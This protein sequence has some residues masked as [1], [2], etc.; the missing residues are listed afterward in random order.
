[1]K[2]VP[3]RL[4]PAGVS[5]GGPVFNGPLAPESSQEYDNEHE[6]HAHDIPRSAYLTRKAYPSRRRIRGR[7]LHKALLALPGS[8]YKGGTLDGCPLGCVACERYHKEESMRTLASLLAACF[9]LGTLG[10]GCNDPNSPEYWI[11]KLKDI[12]ERKEARRQLVRLDKPEAVPA[13]IDLYKEDK[14]PET[15]KALVHFHDKRSIPLLISVIQE[16]T[17]ESVDAASVAAAELGNLGDPQA[18]DP[19]IK[20]LEKKLPIRS[21]ANI[22]KQEAMRSLAKFG[23]EPRVVDALMKMLTTS[24]DEQDFFLNKFAAVQLGVI[25]DPKAVPALIKGLFMTGRGADIFQECR[26]ALVRIGEPAVDPLIELFQEKNAEVNEM[27]KALEFDKHTPG[28]IPAKAAYVLGDLRPK[29]ALPLL[30]ARLKEKVKDPR[31]NMRIS[32]LVTLGQYGD[33]SVIPDILA[34]LKDNTASDLERAKAAEALNFIGDRKVLPE[35]FACVSNQKT[36]PNVRVA[37]GFAYAS[38]GTLAEYAKFEPLANKDAYEEFKMAL[39]RLKLAK[40]CKEDAACY[41]KVFAGSTTQS[42]VLHQMLKAAYELG[43]LERNAALR[44]ILE[45][46]GKTD[47]LEVE[48]ALLFALMRQAGKDCKECKEKLQA[49][50]ERQ[51]KSPTRIAKV[52]AN[53]TKVTLAL[54]GR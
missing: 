33:P 19:L 45:N 52:L 47:Q 37:C 20:V 38:L 43:R 6:M 44:V 14:D 16:F 42:E 40:E 13:L 50:L 23:K 28:V 32:I 8:W 7:R 1:M 2:A 35:L 10:A 4:K 49:Y 31:N 48:Q 11:R 51:E 25:A 30:A 9:I 54:L 53:E 3:V 22:V 18:I 5:S 26:L 24:A 15:L 39:E 27:R 36:P 12:R 34:V 41:G 17:E 46:L 21:R 29:K